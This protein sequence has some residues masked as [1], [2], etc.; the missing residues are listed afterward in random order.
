[1]FISLQFA[2]EGS[3]VSGVAPAVLCDC[4]NL[5]SLQFCSLSQSLGIWLWLAGEW[6]WHPL[7]LMECAREYRRIR[8]KPFKY[9][10]AFVDFS[11]WL[12]EL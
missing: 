4:W 9:P 1:M 3:A 10:E 2:P 8:L 12:A 5:G 11:G 6:N 7:F